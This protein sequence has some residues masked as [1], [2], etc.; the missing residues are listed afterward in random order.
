LLLSL[1]V[2]ACWGWPACAQESMSLSLVSDYVYRGRTLSDGRPSA[3][4][5]WAYDDAA[6][7][8]GGIS[9]APA[10][11][12]GRD[13]WELEASPYAGFAGR[14]SAD[15]SWDAGLRWSRYTLS[16]NRNYSE[17]FLGF[18]NGR[19][20]GRAFLVLNR[21]GLRTPGR[22]L[23]LAYGQALA[24]AVH[25]F[26]HVGALVHASTDQRPPAAIAPVQW[27]F[28]LGV[29]WVNDGL[30]YRLA[31]LGSRNAPW[32]PPGAGYA[33]YRSGQPRHG[34]VAS[35]SSVF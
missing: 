31:A 28:S 30:A 9:A 17:L 8:Y 16:S 24:V 25:G 14:V 3:K 13:R 11:F 32:Q 4:L 34:L 7:W 33:D 35:L 15:F 22:Y 20:T 5:G 26:G 21:P 10:R 6:G 29:E 2:G 19:L 12:P 18:D 1:G 27:D 23:E